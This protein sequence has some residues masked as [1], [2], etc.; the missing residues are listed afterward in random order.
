MFDEEDLPKPKPG[1]QPRKLEGLS[2]EDLQE[3]L[4]FLAQEK[5][6]AEEALKAKTSIE[7]AAAA[8]FKS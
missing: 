5:H 1:L 2:R 3:Y 7:A 6:R 4:D 8:L